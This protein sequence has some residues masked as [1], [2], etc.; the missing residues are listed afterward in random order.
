MKTLRIMLFSTLMVLTACAGAN[1]EPA[2]GANEVGVW[3]AA[4]TTVNDVRVMANPDSWVGDRE[5]IDHVTPMKV[6][7]TNNS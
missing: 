4:V 6:T 5:V 3:D 7:V 1:F 2:Q